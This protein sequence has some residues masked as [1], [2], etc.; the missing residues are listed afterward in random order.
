MRREL[1]LTATSGHAPT[2]DARPL[3]S[4]WRFKS[5]HPH[6]RSYR[7]ARSLFGWV[8]P[9]PWLVSQNPACAEAD[10][11]SWAR[12]VDL[13]PAKESLYAEFL[14]AEWREVEPGIFVL[15][16]R[17]QPDPPHLQALAPTA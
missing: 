6:S 3:R 16:E 4:A 5:S 13:E 14:G 7:R 2:P 17:V 12:G 10:D 9:D 8:D 11:M 15:A 1:A